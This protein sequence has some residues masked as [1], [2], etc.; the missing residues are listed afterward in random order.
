MTSVLRLFS[1]KWGRRIVIGTPYLWLG[2]FF[3]LPFLMTLKIAFSTSIVGI[4]PIGPI[5]TITDDG[6]LQITLHLENWSYLFQDPMY[7]LAYGR[8]LLTALIT[9]VL[10]LF[11]GYPM[12]YRIARATPGAR[13]LLLMLVIM[14]FWTSFLIRVY[15]WM[16]ILKDNGLLNNLLLTLG[17]IHQPLILMNTQIAVYIVMAYAYLPFMLLPLYTTLEKMDLSLLEAAQ[18]LGGRPFI[19][20]LLVT[21]PL[22]LPGIIAGSLL[23]F[24]PAVGEFLIPTLVGSPGHQLIASVIFDEFFSNRDWPTASA[25]ATAVVLFLLLPIILLVWLRNRNDSKLLATGQ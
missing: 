19:S 11:I 18:D 15:A 22:S 10:C 16:G 14:P 17:V 7:V 13:P 25:V 12:A 23:V 1:G 4:P 2:V 21:L 6:A 9:T 5:S 8:S 20:F 24:I 3:L